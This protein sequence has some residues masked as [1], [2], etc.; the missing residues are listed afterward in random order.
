[1]G[2]RYAR[3]THRMSEAL[4]ELTQLTQ[5]INNTQDHAERATAYGQALALIPRVQQELRAGR[6]TEVLAMRDA[7]L[8]D[9]EIGEQIGGLHW[10]RVSAIARGVSSGGSGWRKGK[11]QQPPAVA[12]Q[13]QPPIGDGQHDPDNG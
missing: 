9:A 2:T 12:E 10:S 4:N 1:M 5:A 3:Y 11:K 8:K 7:G 6:Q 13:P